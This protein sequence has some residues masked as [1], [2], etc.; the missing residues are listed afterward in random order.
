MRRTRL[1]TRRVHVTRAQ[2]RA[3]LELLRALQR[4]SQAAIHENEQ[5]S[6]PRMIDARVRAPPQTL[7]WRPPHDALRRTA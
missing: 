4:R 3:K 1:R 6:P 7:S 2:P 5:A